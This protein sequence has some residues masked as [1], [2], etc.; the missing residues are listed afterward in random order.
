[1]NLTNVHIHTVE[2]SPTPTDISSVTE[3]TTSDLSELDISQDKEVTFPEFSTPVG[4]EERSLEDAASTV[5][6]RTT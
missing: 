2:G 6:H 1:M 3:I 5:R 4:T